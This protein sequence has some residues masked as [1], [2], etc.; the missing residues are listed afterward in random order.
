MDWHNDGDFIKF[1]YR[2]S[3]LR[4]LWFVS[5]FIL[6]ASVPSFAGALMDSLSDEELASILQSTP[7]S[8]TLAQKA[9]DENPAAQLTFKQFPANLGRN[10]VGL[11]TFQNLP[12]FL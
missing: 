1:I 10:F 7:Q 5:F 4:R 11:F 6:L 12:P 3:M 2:N 8:P 9:P